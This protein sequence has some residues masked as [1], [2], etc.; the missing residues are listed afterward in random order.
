MAGVVPPPALEALRARVRVIERG[1]G[2]SPLHSLPLGPAALD[3][4]LP[5]GGLPLA[6][7]HEIEGERAE[8][9]DGAVAGFCLALLTRLAAVRPGPLLWAGVR[10]DLHGP[11]LRDFGL[12]PGRL[13][14][15]RAGNDRDVLWALEEGLRAGVLAG[16]VGEV[17]E[18]ER[19]A[20]RRLQLAAEAAGLPC[21]LL[22]RQR[23]APRGREQPSAAVTRWRVAALPAAPVGAVDFPGTLPAGVPLDGLIGRPRWRVEL[24]RCRGAAPAEFLVEW[25]HAAGDFAL[26]TAL[27][28]RSPASA[29]MP[30]RRAG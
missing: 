17:G 3:G 4:R 1:A 26:A 2:A 10:L 28:D 19:G 16:V 27:R 18:L 30:L 8:W 29:P 20:G 22:R 15:A 23:F 25:D 9:D 11:G 6:G 24:L 7:L 14:L 12:D 5:G 13:L 21:F